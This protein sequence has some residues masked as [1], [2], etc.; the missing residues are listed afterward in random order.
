MG[1]I[2]H[3]LLCQDCV[4][5]FESSCFHYRGDQHCEGSIGVFLEEHQVQDNHS[6]PVRHCSGGLGQ[7][8]Q[9]V[10][11]EVVWNKDVHL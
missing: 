11:M 8:L 1:R 7:R 9:G 5:A 10:G 4:S 6:T 3:Y 2:H